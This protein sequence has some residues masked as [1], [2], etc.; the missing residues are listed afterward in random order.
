MDLKATGVMLRR[1]TSAN[2]ASRL[3]G[4]I[5]SVVAWSSMA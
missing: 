5:S 1:S 2:P 4:A 3:Q